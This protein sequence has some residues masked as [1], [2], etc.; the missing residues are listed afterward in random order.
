MSQ[1]AIQLYAG[2]L[3]KKDK[4]MT[5]MALSGEFPYSDILLIKTEWK[6]GE[7]FLLTKY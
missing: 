7:S 5:L 1:N 2:W 3:N 4:V 6:L